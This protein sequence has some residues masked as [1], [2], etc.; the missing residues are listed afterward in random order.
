MCDIK[1]EKGTFDQCCNACGASKRK[2]SS[3]TFYTVKIG[4]MA[5]NL[6]KDCLAVLIGS[7]VIA[8]AS[9]KAE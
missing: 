8:V 9:D 5:N 4:I 1:I 6:C 3:A 7:I 2:G